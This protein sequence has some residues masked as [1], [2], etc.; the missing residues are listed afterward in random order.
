MLTRIFHSF[1]GIEGDLSAAFSRCHRLEFFNELL[2]HTRECWL[3]FPMLQYHPNYIFHWKKT[4]LYSL[5]FS[6]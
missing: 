5:R 1:R 2:H 4:L 3:K 6:A